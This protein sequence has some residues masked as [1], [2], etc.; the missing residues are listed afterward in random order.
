LTEAII[1][2]IQ[3]Q[4]SIFL[5]MNNIIF[6]RITNKLKIPNFIELSEHLSLSEIQS[7]FLKIVESKVKTK[8]PDKILNEYQS[9][10]FVQPSDI[11][12]IVHRTLD[13]HIFSL[14]PPDF[15]LIDLSPLTPLGTASVLTTVHQ[16]NIVSTIRNTEVAADTTN[17]L[18]LECALRRKKLFQKDPKSTNRIKLCSS[19]RLTRAQPF[20]GKYFSA[21][22]C[23]IALCT[24]GKD[25]GNDKFE[26]E[27][28]IEHIDFYI[29]VLDQLADKDEINIK[30][31]KLFEYEGYDNT[32]LFK[33][34][35][36]QYNLRQDI[37]IKTEKN[38]GFGKGYYMRL[39]FGIS[40]INRNKE[41]FDYI[42]GGFV[43]W[44]GNLLNNKKERLLT[45]GIGTDFLL[46]TIKTKISTNNFKQSI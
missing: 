17:I 14:L 21:H 4:L 37:C 45:S 23:V 29:R 2:D 30:N 13:L 25:E 39:R 33:M 38:S 31:I 15:E 8:N 7:L 27:A 19:Q 24:A 9:N 12:P 43:N 20:E 10:R 6:E 46:R 26:V 40:V 28:L 36:N 41:E 16:N 42:D 22:F 5:R 44:T 1:P 32:S 3:D 34:I 11:S 18:A 35:E